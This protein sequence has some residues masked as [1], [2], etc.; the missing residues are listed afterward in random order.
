MDL[1]NDSYLSPLDQAL[2]QNCPQ[3]VSLLLRA[4]C[5]VE[6]EQ[7]HVYYRGHLS[8]SALY[9][10]I[11]NQDTANVR[12]F[13]ACGYHFHRSTLENILSS[14]DFKGE[15]NELGFLLQKA[16]TVPCTLFSYSRQAVRHAILNKLPKGQRSLEGQ[17][18]RLELP[19]SIKDYLA[20]RA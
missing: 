20:M 18:N 4:G 8:N 12:L 10:L 2:T 17:I 1:L 13:F 9:S 19:T 6:K 11:A 7:G 3:I 5:E 15:K 14:Q 16:I